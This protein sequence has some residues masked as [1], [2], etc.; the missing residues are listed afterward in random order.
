[1]ED[2]VRRIL[3]TLPGHDRDLFSLRLERSERDLFDPL[4]RLYGHQ[5]GYDEFVDALRLALAR[6]W[7]ERP[8]DLR[9]LDLRRDLNPDWF[10]SERMVGYV[11]YIDRFAGRLRDVLD[12]VDYLEELG[13][14]YVHFMP[15][16][17]PR[18]GESDGGYSVQDYGAIDP[19]Y[20]TLEDFEAV[21]E[22][23]R[24]RGI[25]TCI[26]LVVNHTA[27][28]HAWAEAARSGSARHLAYYRMYDDPTIPQQYESTLLEVFPDQAPGNFTYYDDLGKWVWTTF[29]EHQWD[30][31]WENPDV[32]LEFVEIMLTLANGGA[33]VF[34]LDAVAFMWKR[35]GTICQNQPE[36]HDILQ[37]LRAACRIA[38]PAIIQKA[39]AIVPPTDLL[40]Y[41]GTGRH[42]GKV[43]N[44]AYHN[45][46][47]VQFWSSLASRDTALMTHVLRSHFPPGHRNATWGTYLRCH[48]DI[49]WAVTEEDAGA[50]GLDGGAH[51]AF[52]ADFYEGLFPGTFAKGWRFQHNPTTGDRRTNGTLASLSGLER[53]LEDGSADGVDT[54]IARILMGHALIAGWGGVPLLYMGDELGML[55]DYGFAAEGELDSRWI[56]R[57]AMDWTTAARRTD[58]SSVAG[59]IFIGVQ[60]IL[61][62]R[63]ATPQL[64]GDVPREVLEPPSHT[65]FAF[66]RRAAEGPLI[67]LSNFCEETYWLHRDWPATVGLHGEIVDL[68]ARDTPHQEGAH[69]RILPYQTLW[70]TGP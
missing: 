37:A 48:D 44:L 56:H 49:G 13:V 15:C 8:L 16:L 6:H 30:L 20:G 61:Q 36:V 65:L 35:M 46:L 59:R 26:D 68:L 51:R 25:S 19:R 64:H 47:M 32:F 60:H 38:A 1:M 9:A 28:E 54:A 11:F 66:A 31:N 42:T 40:A 18:Q 2:P 69:L 4:H 29:N 55:N 63:K 62:T 7:V 24:A 33:E 17:K 3:A 34:R 23:L 43:A 21:T 14:T 41:L 67:A 52:L 45:S 22:A 10:L 70:L 53:A 39:E 5:P 50:V 27:K 12:H 57:P 58:P